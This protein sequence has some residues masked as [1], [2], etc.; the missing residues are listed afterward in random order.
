MKSNKL[1]LLWLLTIPLALSGCVTGSIAR[2]PATVS[3][4]CLIAKPIGYD[5]TKDTPETVK[6]IEAHNSQW[7]CVCEKDCPARPAG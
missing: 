3:D 4:Y 5:S 6:A 2:A 7:V 1:K